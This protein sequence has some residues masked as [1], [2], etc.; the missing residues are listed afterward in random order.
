MKN[1]KKL[2]LFI[3]SILGAHALYAN[4]TTKLSVTTL[5][6]DK[7]ISKQAET[8][9]KKLSLDMKN[10]KSAVLDASGQNEQ[11]HSQAKNYKDPLAFSID[12]RTGN[13]SINENIIKLPGKV[14]DLDLTLSLQYDQSSAEFQQENDQKRHLLGLPA[15]WNYGLSYIDHDQSGKQVLHVNGSASYQVESDWKTKDGINTSLRY[16]DVGN[17]KFYDGFDNETPC[18]NATKYVSKLVYLNGLTQYFSAGGLLLCQ[19]DNFNNKI[20]YAYH[21]AQGAI[22]EP[23][24]YNAALVSVMGSYGQKVAIKNDGMG[25]INIILPDKRQYTL[26]YDNISLQSIKAPDGAISTI[27]YM[28]VSPSQGTG[29]NYVLPHQIA[30]ATG[31]VVDLTY[32]SILACPNSSLNGSCIGSQ[33]IALPVVTKEVSYPEGENGNITLET[34]YNFNVNTGHGGYSN[35]YTGYPYYSPYGIN[36]ANN[37][38]DGLMENSSIANPYQV[39]VTKVNNQNGKR[40][41]TLYTYNPLHLL[42]EQKQY[43]SQNNII[44][45]TV[46]RYPANVSGSSIKVLPIS[47]LPSNYQTPDW[48]ASCKYNSGE[49]SGRYHLVTTEFNPQGLPVTVKTYDGVENA[50]NQQSCDPHVTLSSETL[51]SL[52]QTVQTTIYDV[53]AKAPQEDDGL[54]GLPVT[55]EVVNYQHDGATSSHVNILKLNTLSPDGKVIQSSITGAVKDTPALNSLLGKIKRRAQ[56]SSMLAEDISSSI[57]WDTS[58][59]LPKQTNYKYDS[60]GRNTFSGLSWYQSPTLMMALD[61]KLPSG[62][63]STHSATSYKQLPADHFSCASNISDPVLQ[64]T[65]T[66]AL[67]HNKTKLICLSNGELLSQTDAN[68]NTTQYRYNVA[69]QKIAEIQ[70]NGVCTATQ[71][72]YANNQQ[73]EQT[74][75]CINSK[76]TRPKLPDGFTGNISIQVMHDLSKNSIKSALDGDQNIKVFDGAGNTSA[77]LD[78]L[79]N[80]GSLRVLE[81]DQYNDFGQLESKIKWPD[82]LALKSTYAYDDQGRQISV[83][84]AQGNTNTKLYDDLNQ[85]YMTCFNGYKQSIVFL[86]NKGKPK[87]S[88]SIPLP[89]Q[90]SMDLSAQSLGVAGGD[91]SWSSTN[92]SLTS[93]IATTVSNSD[94]TL[95]AQQFYDGLGNPVNTI[96]GNYQLDNTLS[97]G[98]MSTDMMQRLDANSGQ[99]QCKSGQSDCTNAH[100]QYDFSNKLT[101][102]L[103]TGNYQSNG[104]TTQQIAKSNWTRDLFGNTASKTLVIQNG[105]SLQTAA[106]GLASEDIADSD[107]YIYNKTNQLISESTPEP[108]SEGSSLY[109]PNYKQHTEYWMYDSVG[110]MITHTSFAGVKFYSQYDNMNRNTQICYY[111]PQDPSDPSKP[112][113]VTQ[114]KYDTISGQPLVAY[115]FDIADTKN[116]TPGEFNPVIKPDNASA[117][118]YRYDSA[119]N[120]ISKTVFD[121][122]VGLVGKTQDQGIQLTNGYD[123]QNRL[124]CTS[125]AVAFDHD[126]NCPT[127]FEVG[128]VASPGQYVTTYQ[129]YNAAEPQ[130]QGELHA[131]CRGSDCIVYDYYTRGMD[132]GAYQAYAGKMMSKAIIHNPINSFDPAK[133]PSTSSLS[134]CSVASN[135]PCI[136]SDTFYNYDDQKRPLSITTCKDA[137]C[138]PLSPTADDVILSISYRYDHLNRITQTVHQSGEYP[139][140]LD[141]NYDETYGY[142]SLSRLIMDTVYKIAQARVGVSALGVSDGAQIQ[143]TQYSYDSAGNVMCKAVNNS[144]AGMDNTGLKTYRQTFSY[145]V[146]N[147]LIN[148]ITQDTSSTLAQTTC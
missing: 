143:K 116:C 129:Y 134:S 10:T 91:C 43:D 102:Y 77:V 54:Y 2:S 108:V 140:N 51:S 118:S 114:F 27:K 69:G 117:I 78:N 128:D 84:D 1:W 101:Q 68:G 126:Q 75:V 81:K 74:D 70:P 97:F 20:S 125:D 80:N 9:H 95:S 92:A 135:K 79:G 138:S 60:T 5:K 67:G 106:L 63:A 88:F 55:Q 38:L 52:L 99:Y 57:D 31:L 37:G 87:S 35:N 82:S 144:F 104:Q 24:P 115:K 110:N 132:N 11:N 113:Y 18:G 61:N 145:N 90:R 41:S 58:K 71:I 139:D 103:V 39:R 131:V 50:G 25:S 30:T 109:D 34:D 12:N 49:S 53:P 44:S 107:S 76:V 56:L 48:V 94:D 16:Y 59:G 89:T 29:Q 93:L 122:V 42:A 123:H 137:Q 33:T 45:D 142:D 19:R 4:Q 124:T 15:G 147:Q 13:V 83:T 86:N 136:I 66:D 133:L 85:R 120:T 96:V 32:G 8:R 100:S 98:T 22:G 46:Y 72:F 112:Y 6:Q 130:K 65:S 14:S 3:S 7:P 111:D 146:D 21:L 127:Y 40:I 119:G 62:P 26:K 36:S 17:M 64:V 148:Q 23:T 47:Q 141:L 73:V 105:S 28:T 121:P